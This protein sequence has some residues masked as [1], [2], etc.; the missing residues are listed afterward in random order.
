MGTMWVGWGFSYRGRKSLIYHM[1]PPVLQLV[2]LKIHIYKF[3]KK[4]TNSNATK[5]A[6]DLVTSISK[7]EG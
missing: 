1:H 5:C 2:L 7:K 4:E 6:D 3:G